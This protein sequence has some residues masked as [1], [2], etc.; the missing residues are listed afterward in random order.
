MYY[1]LLFSVYIGYT[2]ALHCY[3]TL[4]LPALLQN[5]STLYVF[6]SVLDVLAEYCHILSKIL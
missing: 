3:I 5:P 6:T 2:N 1:F 4:T